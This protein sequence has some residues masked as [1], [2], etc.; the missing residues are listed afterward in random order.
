MN[1]IYN[2]Y[3]GNI[4]RVISDDQDYLVYHERFP[5]EYVDSLAVLQV[6]ELP[7]KWKNCV[8]VNNKFVTRPIN[9][10]EEIKK[11]GKVLTEEERLSILLQPSPEEITKAKNTIEI[12]SML[13]EVG[14]L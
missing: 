12:L 7:N 4:E 13:Q 1:V 11:Y 3:S 8:I 2:K 5:K 14:V 6:S 10:L 9:E